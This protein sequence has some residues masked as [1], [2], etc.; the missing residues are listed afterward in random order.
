MVLKHRGGCNPHFDFFEAGSS[1]LPVD[2][3]VLVSANLRASHCMAT[4]LHTSPRSLLAPWRSVTQARG[5]ARS[6]V[7]LEVLPSFFCP[8]T[9]KHNQ[10]FA[11]GIGVETTAYIPS[12]LVH[13][14]IAFSMLSP[15]LYILSVDKDPTEASR[16]SKQSA[17]RAYNACLRH[18]LT[19]TDTAR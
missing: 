10:L 17:K 11:K 18:H 14:P 8:P 19:S 16:I 4:G 6:G 5:I 3:T 1:Q 7:A 15:R 13:I 12:L 9:G 2:A